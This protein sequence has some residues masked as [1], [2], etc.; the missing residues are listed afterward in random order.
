M[1]PGTEQLSLALRKVVQLS[2][3]AEEEERPTET[4]KSR[5]HTRATRE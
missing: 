5:L 1:S 3:E 4:P 2:E